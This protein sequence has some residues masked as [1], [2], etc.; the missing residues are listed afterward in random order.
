MFKCFSDDNKHR[1]A[2]LAADE[3]GITG[4]FLQNQL[5]NHFGNSGIFLNADFVAL[6]VAVNR[7]KQDYTS[8]GQQ[9]MKNVR[10]FLPR[11]FLTVYRII[12]Y[13]VS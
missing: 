2:A 5:H 12:Q 8:Q 3:T 9:P 4:I 7:Y 10:L 6:V 13:S 1:P 11:Q